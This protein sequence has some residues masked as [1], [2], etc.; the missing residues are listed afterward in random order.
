MLR[1]SYDPRLKCL[2]II[3]EGKLQIQDFMDL[4]EKFAVDPRPKNL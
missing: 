1:S 3:G 2:S 4:I